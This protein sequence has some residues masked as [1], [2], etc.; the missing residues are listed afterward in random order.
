[1]RPVVIALFPAMAKHGDSKQCASL[2][3]TLNCAF[4]DVCAGVIDVREVR[5]NP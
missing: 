5:R 1:M 3:V 2:T 4:N